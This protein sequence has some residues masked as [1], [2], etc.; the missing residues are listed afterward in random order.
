M[1]KQ[2]VQCI[3]HYRPGPIDVPGLFWWKG[4]DPIKTNLL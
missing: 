1:L 4:D 3:Y 2:E